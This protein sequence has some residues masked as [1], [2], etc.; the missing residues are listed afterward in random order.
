M[1]NLFLVHDI[2]DLSQKKNLG[3]VST[4][5]TTNTFLLFRKAL[6]RV[7]NGLSYYTQIHPQCLKLV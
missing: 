1:D 5:W 6:E 7:L 2:L 4:M 3:L